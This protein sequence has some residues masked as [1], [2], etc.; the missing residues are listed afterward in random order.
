LIQ[1]QSIIKSC[2]RRISDNPPHARFSAQYALY[3]AHV[4]L[5]V[6]EWLQPLLEPLSMEMRDQLLDTFNL[7]ANQKKDPL[8][9]FK[10]E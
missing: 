1:K 5:H 3:H 2:A 10:E 4:V 7:L 8:L 9:D 6:E